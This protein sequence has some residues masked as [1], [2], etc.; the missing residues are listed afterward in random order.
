M[1]RPSRFI[2]TDTSTFLAA[3][4]FK[5]L[6]LCCC[7]GLAAEGILRAGVSVL[8]IDITK[9]SFYPGTF[10]QGD[11]TK[12]EL[13]FVQLFNF[14]WASPPCQ[15]QS[16]GTSYARQQGKEYVNLIPAMR[17]I[18]EASG[19]PGVI[20]NIPETGIRPDFMLCGSMFDLPQ[21]RH[22]HF[23]CINWRPQY[24]K[25]YCDH[26]KNKGKNHV[27]AGAFKGTIHDAAVS[28]GCEPTRLRSEIKEGIPPAYSE[29]IMKTFLINNAPGL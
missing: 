27:L 1:G 17:E 3:P 13:T 4:G 10:L 7:S 11:A 19:L 23:E 29:F 8:G 9:P 24:I 12:T 18:I 16:R 6:D 15:F 28:M 5:V 20:E 25:P 26:A 2:D 21:M 14:V 22:R